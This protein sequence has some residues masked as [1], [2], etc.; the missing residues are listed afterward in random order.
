MEREPSRGIR[1]YEG[2]QRFDTRARACFAQRP[3]FREGRASLPR[4]S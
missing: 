3:P 1:D 4:R 2:R